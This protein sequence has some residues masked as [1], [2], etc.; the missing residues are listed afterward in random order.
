M[1]NMVAMKAL[2]FMGAMIGLGKGAL[3]LPEQLKRPFWKRNAWGGQRGRGWRGHVIEGSYFGKAMLRH[4]TWKI[5]IKE[6]RLF[7]H[8]KPCRA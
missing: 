8:R 6:H 2:A 3:A 5:N 7:Q 4:I 1:G